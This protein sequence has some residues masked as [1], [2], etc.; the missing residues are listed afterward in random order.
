MVSSLEAVLSLAVNATSTRR[1]HFG[2]T[3][4][5]G[6]VDGPKPS[7]TGGRWPAEANFVPFREKPTSL[8][9]PCLTAPS[10]MAAPQAAS[11]ILMMS[12]GINF[13]T[14]S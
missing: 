8:E 14:V 3:W 12:P 4:S 6:R 7:R 13:S 9:K 2:D 1:S 10:P 11:R 5:Q